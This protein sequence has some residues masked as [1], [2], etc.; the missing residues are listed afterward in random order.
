MADEPTVAPPVPEDTPTPEAPATPDTP[1]TPD[2][3]NAIDYEQRYTELR[4]E[5]DR[6]N[7]LLADIE[8]RRG[9]E[10]QARALAEHARIELEGDDAEPELE[11]EFDLPPDPL[12]EIQAIKQELA[13]EREAKQAEE[14]DQ[15]EAEYTEKTVEGL[16]GKENLKLSDAEYEIVVN[17]GFANRDAHDGKPDLEGGFNALKIV[18]EAGRK[19]YTA[20]KD[21]AVLAPVGATG[22]PKIDLRDKEQRQK[23]G[24][25]VFEAAERQKT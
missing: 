14:F 6:R 17:Y 24:R 20:S 11:D 15:L 13:E 23:L 8:G 1:D 21:D 2:S 4:S 19:R 25:E 9:P 12:D 7:E 22:E 10:A 18:Q 5:F 16:E 3:P